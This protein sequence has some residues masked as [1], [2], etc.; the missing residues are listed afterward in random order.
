VIEPKLLGDLLAARGP[1]GAEGPASAVWGDAAAA[2]AEIATDRLGN[3]VATVAAEGPLLLLASHIDEIGLSITHVDERGFLRV[4]TIGGWEA[5]VGVGQRIVIAG[6]N[7]PVHGVVAREPDPQRRTDKRDEPGRARW[8]DIFVDIG[9]RTEAEA[10]ALVRPGDPATIAGDAV[11][12]SPGRIASRALDN[13]VGAYVVLEAARRLAES[14][15]PSCRIAALAA[16]EE[17]TGGYGARAA[18]FGLDPDVAV[19]VDITDATDVPG[20]DPKENGHR[21][22]GS[23]PSITRGPVVT[24]AIVDALLET[25]EREGIA[26][27]YDVPNW[28]TSTDADEIVGSRAGIPTGLVS[29]P[30]RHVHTPVEVVDLSDVEDAIRLIVAFAARLPDVGT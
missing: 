11:E 18:T 2:F 14:E 7:G 6:S 27:T 22:L 16:V 8:G 25:A 17:E 20:A 29:V 19:V 28:R 12:L 4:R 5:E 1:A 3:S 13:R 26:V 30:I 10:R 9:S 21:P 15:M 23:G 24:K